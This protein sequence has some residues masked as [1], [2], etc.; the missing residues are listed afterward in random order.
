MKRS[1]AILLSVVLTLVAML[2]SCSRVYDE[3]EVKAAAE[4]LLRDSMMLNSV[5]FGDGIRSIAN[6]NQMGNYRE[7]DPTHLEELG[8][9]SILELKALTYKTFS[10]E[11]S[12]KIFASAFTPLQNDGMIVMNTRYYQAV[13]E[14]T[15]LPTHI[16]VFK[17]YKNQI[18]EDNLESYDYSSIKIERAKGDIIYLTVDC[19]VKNDEGD[20]QVLNITFSMYEEEDGWK[21]NSYTYANYNEYI[22]SEF[23]N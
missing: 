3:D 18:F 16:M 13:D 11:M 5:Y 23:F 17:D 6:D 7:A 8:F 15:K 1:I 10:A 20:S 21:L 4:G 12:E 14:E 22:D 2:S 9:Q 19:V